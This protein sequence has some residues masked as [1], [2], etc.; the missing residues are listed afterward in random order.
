[1]FAYTYGG[2]MVVLSSSSTNP[3]TYRATTN[4]GATETIVLGINANGQTYGN[5]GG[6]QNQC[7][8]VNEIGAISQGGVTSFQGTT[9]K[10]VTSGTVALDT[11]SI[12]QGQANPT[13]YGVPQ[14]STATETVGFGTAY[15]GNTYLFLGGT[16]TT[17][18]VVSFLVYNSSLPGGQEQVSYTVMSG[19]TLTSIATALVA[20]LNADV[21]LAALGITGAYPSSGGFFINQPT[22]SYTWSANSGA[23]ES[24]NL[25][26]NLNGNTYAEIDGT[27]TP[28]D[29]LTITTNS[30]ALPGGQESVTYTVQPSDDT[31]AIAAGLGALINADSNLSA[32]KIT[33]SNSGQGVPNWSEAFTA[34]VFSSGNN[35]VNMSATDGGGNTASTPY[36][37]YYNGNYAYPSFDA[38][39]NM[40]SDGTNS[41]KW[42]AENR[43][44]EID[45]PGT[46][47]SSQ[48]TYDG[49]GQ[50]VQ[51]VENV[52][53]TVTSTRQF[54]WSGEKAEARDV[55]GNLI[56]QF[57]GTG[58]INFTGST[59]SVY[60]YAGDLLNS[61]REVTDTSSNVQA[62][63]GFDPYG[64]MVK[65]S[66]NIPSDFT[67]AGYYLHA[68]SG[69][70]LTETRAYSPTVGRWINRDRVGESGGLNLF[71]YVGNNPIG[72]TDPTGRAP[73]SDLLGQMTAICGDK[74]CVPCPLKQKCIK[75]AEAI[76]ARLQ[77][78]WANRRY[79]QPGTAGGRYWSDQVN[80]YRCWDFATYFYEAIASVS[81]VIWHASFSN[82]NSPNTSVSPSNG[83]VYRDTHW[84]VY[85]GTNDLWKCNLTIDDGATMEGQVHSGRWGTGSGF[86]PLTPNAPNPRTIYT[87]QP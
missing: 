3:T 76:N 38:N 66:E 10:A 59:G 24:I 46:G 25:G 52:G 83:R 39:G 6:S 7:N 35:Y 9:N 60:F 55:S 11:I 69:L 36:Q 41:Y 73:M 45:Y 20:A 47:N 53:G 81:P 50:N 84:A 17:G 85:L 28:G 15:N 64:R 82:W 21:N 48:F 74:D 13:T 70:S 16:V 42:D 33:A 43:L 54:V 57:F 72:Y 29:T 87:I 79:G 58:Q 1:M 77:S 37:V 18:D 78:V 63:Y 61:I 27:P 51:I 5:F 4:A 56:A 30:G 68:R 12:Q 32:I 19:D 49:S 80:G 8:N 22:T 86:W 75:E 34:N 62:E 71:G 65:F 14:S 2:P 40:T 26:N 23:T 31:I 44:V 67:Y